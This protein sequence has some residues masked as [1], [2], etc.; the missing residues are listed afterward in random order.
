MN[1]MRLTIFHKIALVILL[2]LV[3]ILMLYSYS[4]RVSENVVKDEIR[5]SLISR[6][7]YLQNRLNTQVIH[8]SLSAMRLSGDPSLATLNSPDSF[9]SHF[10]MLQ[11][12][13]ELQERIAVQSN[14]TEWPTDLA[15]YFPASGQVVSPGPEIA[16]DGRYIAN[17]VDKLWKAWPKSGAIG[18]GYD[19]YYYA[20]S[21]YSAYA[22]PL[23]ANNIVEIRFSSSNLVRMLDEYKGAG[24]SDPFLSDGKNGLIANSTVDQGLAYDVMRELSN[25]PAQDQLSFQFDIGG[26]SYLV[27][28]IRNAALGW[29][30]VDYVPME[31]V[32]RPIKTSNRMFYISSGLLLLLAIAAVFLLYRNVQIPMKEL[33]R[34]LQRIK[35]GDFSARIEI[36]S[37]TEFEFLFQRFNEMSSQ[38]GDLIQ[39]VYRE[40][41]T[42]RDAQFKQLQSQINPHFLYNCLY[43]IVNMVRLG[44][45]EAAEQMA[46]SLG[47]Y[48]K[49]TT[50]LER[51]DATLSEEIGLI[52]NYLNIQTLRMRRIQFVIDIPEAMHELEIPRLLLQPIVENSVIHGIE[53]KLGGGEIRIT[54]SLTGSTARIAVEDSGVGLTAER[55]A[56][57]TRRLSEPVTSGT[58]YGVW[59]VN[60]RLMLKFGAGAGVTY[61][62]AESGG[63]R[64]V[65]TWKYA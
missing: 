64:V 17:R 47:D 55:M 2:L 59:N 43:F 54:G 30:L 6:L 10:D 27:N 65:L 3:P 58:G 21:P 20:V 34:S 32:L 26:R 7:T 52:E 31:Q 53:P 33:M 9:K 39:H 12:K 14:T 45:D 8:L 1:P 4:N 36:R 19:F 37:G 57:L 49:Y 62:H 61:E 24:R 5:K 50:R 28:S 38:I 29:T 13:S 22:N 51:S 35:R 25:R 23:Q 63:L 48:F 11:F 46:V 42:A 15:V 41:L 56:E 40:Q 16:F 18:S 44:K 60:Q